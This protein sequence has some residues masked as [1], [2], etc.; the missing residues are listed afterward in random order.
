MGK[1]EQKSL[2]GLFWQS[3]MPPEIDPKYFLLQSLKSEKAETWKK[4][5]MR[6]LFVM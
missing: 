1:D 2:W 5:D 6:K 3:A 4:C